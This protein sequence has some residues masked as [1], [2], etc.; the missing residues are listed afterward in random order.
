MAIKTKNVNEKIK[1]VKI[2]KFY[3]HDASGAIRKY[4]QYCRRKG[5]TTEKSYNY[6]NLK[7]KILFQTQKRKHGK[8]KK[9]TQVMSKM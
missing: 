6:E 4:L 2:D 9:R 8:C 5:C 1:C 7:P 3:F